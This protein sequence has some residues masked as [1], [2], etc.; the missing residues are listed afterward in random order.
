[1][2]AEPTQVT[3]LTLEDIQKHL[4]SA[5]VDRYWREPQWDPK[6]DVALTIIETVR[7]VKQA[8][9]ALRPNQSQE[10]PE[11]LE[12]ALQS[13]KGLQGINA[14]KT[15]TPE[16][17]AHFEQ[18]WQSLEQARISLCANLYEKMR[19]GLGSMKDGPPDLSMRPYMMKHGLWPKEDQC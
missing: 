8:R 1:M 14:H 10:A 13:L 5:T 17:Q 18:A 2:L 12:A 15:A 16:Q 7:H 4:L 3:A 11:H 6:Q 9:S 19:P